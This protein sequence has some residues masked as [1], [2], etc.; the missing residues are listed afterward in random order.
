[1]SKLVFTPLFTINPLETLV[2]G[3]SGGAGGGAGGGER[4]ASFCRRAVLKC[5]GE[6]GNKRV[7]C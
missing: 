7:D 6:K 5:H 4:G 1:M 2:D 3:W